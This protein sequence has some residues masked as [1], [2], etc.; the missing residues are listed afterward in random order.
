MFTE[1]LLYEPFFITLTLQGEIVIGLIKKLVTSYI[2]EESVKVAN[3]KRLEQGNRTMEE[4]IQKFRKV[5]SRSKY[6]KRPLV[7][8]FKKGINTTIC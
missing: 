5:A 7:E 8:D 4:F 6:E 1:E 3:L 2:V